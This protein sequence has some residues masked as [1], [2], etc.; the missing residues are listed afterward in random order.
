[1]A[2]KNK[3]AV[4]AIEYG[5]QQNHNN[6]ADSRGDQHDSAY[7]EGGLQAWTVV[8]GAWCA[9]ISSMGLL[10]TLAVLQAWFSEHQLRSMPESAVG[11]IFS[12]YSFFLYFCG[13][14]IGPIFDAIW[15]MNFALSFSSGVFKILVPYVTSS[16]RKHAL[17]ATTSVVANIA[18]G[19]FRLPFAKLLDV[20]GRTQCMNLMVVFT[21]AG[22]L[23]MAACL[24]NVGY[25]GIQFCLVI[26]V[27]DSAPMKNRAFLMGWMSTPSIA[28]IWAYGPATE[29]IL[30]TIGFRWGFG[31][32][33][34]LIPVFCA[35]FLVVSHRLDKK[36][37]ASPASSATP[38]VTP[39]TAKAKLLHYIWDFDVA[40]LLM[41]GT[42]LCF[43]LLSLSIYSYQADGWW[44]PLIVCLLVFGGLLI[45]AFGLY[46]RFLAPVA[47]L[48]WCLISDRTVI[49]TNVMAATLYTS[50]FLCSSY[51]YSL[52]IVFFSQSV[53]QAS[54]I[55]NT[56]LVGASF[57]NIILGI[58]L[59]YY[60]HIKLYTLALGIPF[61]IVGTGLMIYSISGTGSIGLIVFCKILFS[62]GGGTIYPIEQIALMAV[63][64]EHTAALLAVQSVIVDCGK[65]AGS[66]I[67]TAI[68]TSMF[69]KRLVDH[70][71]SMPSENVTDVYGSLDIQSS[72][73]LGG[74]ERLGINAAYAETQRVILIVALC[75]SAVAWISVWF[76][77]DIDVKGPRSKEKEASANDGQVSRRI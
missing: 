58:A 7:P 3:E 49:F 53:T 40:G 36:A 38:S 12:T 6:I 26:F 20:W 70:L 76:W 45:V 1:M 37:L 64:P 24:Y 23:M 22:A 69:R 44:S 21:T 71:S 39:G 27:G 35:P 68:W 61:F 47:F 13:A 75:L 8:L 43:L 62:F 30:H 28:S 74:P 67:G 63:S 15:V 34:V 57:W 29:G 52:L 11:W 50:E 31:M 65:A 10:N 18:S 2:L 54:Y 59:R 73:P 77:E 33:C 66:A 60:G 4:D 9:M 14:Q 17:T 32:W 19:I 46:E 42:G 16:F 51:L 48:P 5:V 55:S 56:Y 72:Y 25:Y 41:L